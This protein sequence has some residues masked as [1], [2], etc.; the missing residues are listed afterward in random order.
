MDP[1]EPGRL[2]KLV[3]TEALPG[4]ELLS[5]AIPQA[6]EAKRAALYTELLT[7]TSYIPLEIKLGLPFTVEM[8]ETYP[9]RQERP[10][11]LKQLPTF[12][13]GSWQWYFIPLKDADGVHVE[14]EIP[15]AAL[16][17]TKLR[18]VA[19]IPRLGTRRI[20]PNRIFGSYLTSSER[21]V[22]LYSSRMQA[23]APQDDWVLPFV[24]AKLKVRLTGSVFFGHAFAAFAAAVAASYIAYATFSHALHGGSIPLA[25]LRV[26]ATVG[27]LS[28]TV[29]LW[30][31]AIQHPR[32]ITFKT[33]ALARLILY[34]A[35]IT[36]L[37]GFVAYGIRRLLA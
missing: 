11:Y 8:S 16:H 27:A 34:T 19:E 14:I 3:Q 4:L 35:L 23:E 6:D 17:I 20:P 26:L 29:G 12:V 9:F 31:T 32:P 7:W 1:H 21:M 15:D 24:R 37:A 28:L 2:A 30:L 22:H 13:L 10:P 33:L 25:D 18:L 36:T 5:K